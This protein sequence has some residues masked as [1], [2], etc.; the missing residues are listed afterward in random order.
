MEKL[1]AAILGPGKIGEFHAREFKNVGCD[2][3]AILTSSEKTAKER[4]EKLKL[5]Y[6]IDAVPYWDLEKLLEKEKPDVVSICTPPE[7][8]SRQIRRCLSY[9]SH[10]L[11]EK[12]LVLDSEYDNHRVVEE[13][14]NLAKSHGKILST[15]TQWISLLEKIP[16]PLKNDIEK[17]S[18][19]M[20]P[21]KKGFVNMASDVLPHMNSFLIK[22]LGQRP[23]ERLDFLLGN[24]IATIAFDYGG[25]PVSYK[26]KVKEER[27]R[28][29]T[30][31]I[32]GVEFERKV[33]NVGGVY[34]NKLEYDGKTMCVED[35]LN[36]SIRR[37]ISAIKGAGELLVS[38]PDA[39]YN[40]KMQDAIIQE[41]E[42]RVK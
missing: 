28:Q 14:F 41:V 12:P 20:E 22:L 33:E 34:R 16:A 15:N 11:C 9:N 36:V 24:E 32:N 37:F 26:M 1:R 30:F 21:A 3:V 38:E 13:L 10:V 18:V 5:S 29:M 27:P 25:V 35:P 42:S 2:V 17:F 40:I 6:G 19:Y 39:L 4:A 7:Y 23:I 31:Y 8:H